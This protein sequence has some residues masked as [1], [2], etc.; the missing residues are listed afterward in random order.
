MTVLGVKKS[1]KEE[2]KTKTKQPERSV[3]FSSEVRD[4][5]PG[6]PW[7]DDEAKRCFYTVRF[8]KKLC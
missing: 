3:R 5:P 4:L 2:T 6:I 8:S 1:S 7:T